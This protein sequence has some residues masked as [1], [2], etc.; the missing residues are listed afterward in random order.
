[1]IGV[2]STIGAGIFVM[3]GTV[4]AQYAGPA[5]ILA[6]LFAAFAC[7][8]TGLC[9][10]E[11][12]AMLP[13]AG[14]AYTYSRAAL[15]HRVAWMVGW[16]LILEYLV[17]ASTVA[18]GWSGYAVGTASRLGF[19]LPHALTSAPF[20]LNSA[21]EL[22]RSAAWL[23]LPAAAIV[24]LMAALLIRGARSSALAN[25]VLG[26]VKVGVIVLVI[27]A[28]FFFVEPTNWSPFIPPNDGSPGAHGWSGVLRAAGII[29]YAYIGF[30]T[31]STCA[32]ETRRPQRD[33]G[34]A[35]I[36]ALAV[37]TTLYVGLALVMTGLTHYSR[38]NVAD[39]ILVAL[40]AGGAGLA[41]IKPLVSIGAVVGLGSTI[42]VTLYGQTRIFYTMSQD[43]ALPPMF[44]R[45]H[46]RYCT[47]VHG[48]VIAGIACAL[49][50][51]S[52]PLDVL[53]ELVSIGT[54]LA[55]AAVCVAVSV[56]R[57]RSPDLPRPFRVPFGHV[58]PVAGTL[59]C[60]Y[61]MYSLPA[62]A[63]WRLTI[64]LALGAGVYLSMRR[65]RRTLG[66]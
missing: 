11:L 28:G 23:N 45:L 3:T 8:L 7:L 35:I 65:L 2:G 39:P 4:A 46:P 37:C 33:L 20:V 13:L 50:A 62:S 21:G 63:W 24:L 43:G 15:G 18:V 14:S 59:A 27:V 26:L 42:L 51:G 52:F 32:Q 19:E 29:F 49:L 22:V 12:A 54:L 55:F 9:Y 25:N 6:F 17:A 58:I 5:V 66:R 40:D 34:V 36:L 10:A 48:V 38:L 31:I 56:L 1:M 16:C 57:V 64:W 44:S 41:W 53:G 47:P 60:L 30:E 61:L